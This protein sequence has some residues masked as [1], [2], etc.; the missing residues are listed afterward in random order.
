MFDKLEDILRRYEDITME[1]G[2]PSAIADQDRFKKLMKE[3]KSLEPLIEC[4]IRYKKCKETIEESLQMLEGES[5]PDMKE[6]LREELAAAKDELPQLESELKVLLLP[7][8]PNDDKNVIVEIRAGVGGDEAALFAADMYRLYTRYAERQNWTVETMS[9]EDI[10]IGGIKTVSF[11]IKGNGAYSRLKFESGVHRVQ[12]I[13]ATESGGR[14]HTSAITVAIMPE[15]ED[16][17]VDIDLNDCKFDVFRAS[18]NGGQCVN[19]TDSA[20]RL[21]H[22]P[23]GIVISCQDEKSQQQNKAKALKVLRAKLYELETQKQHDSEAALRKSQVGSGDRSEKI[24]TYNFHQGRVTDHRIN[25][26]LYKIDQIMDGDLDEI[27]DALIAAD[28]AE[29]LKSQGE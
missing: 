22:F 3:Q 24:R 23:T 15:V 9:V 18:G 21:T 6:M 12:R 19:T 28:Q 4:Y 11:M 25:L 20:V 2:E 16:V 10:G 8:D 27:I 17:E 14:I 13:P 7:K 26:T 29:K 1:L 5:D